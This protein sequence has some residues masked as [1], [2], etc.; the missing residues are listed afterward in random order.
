MSYYRRHYSNPTPRAEIRA[1][2]GL[3]VL[4]CSYSESLVAWLKSLPSQDRAPDKST[5][6]WLWK[7]DPKHATILQ[8]AIFQYLGVETVLPQIQSTVATPRS[9]VADMLYIGGAYTRGSQ[10]ERTATGYINGEWAWIFAEKVLRQFFGERDA[11]PTAL[12]SH[13]AVL[14]VSQGVSEDDLRKAY[15]RA[16]KTW[17]PDV[18]REPDAE[19]QF[20]RIN[21]AYEVLKDP[22]ARERYDAGLI[23]QARVGFGER[24]STDKAYFTPLRCGNLEVIATPAVGG[25]FV[26]NS[27][28]SW[29]DITR[30]GK[31]LITTWPKGYDKFIEQW[32]EV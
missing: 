22:Y 4:D 3:L 16:S 5:G 2:N 10:P 28:K 30:N 32:V 23:L 15:R 13:Y 31:M 12:L 19:Q 25:K 7:I 17:H 8:K 29:Q 24:E 14:G 11:K 27:I 20:K 21:H 6:K 26:I 18:S 1:E 9:I